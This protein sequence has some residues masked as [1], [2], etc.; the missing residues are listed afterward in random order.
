MLKFLRSNQQVFSVFIFIYC[1]ISV[2]SI[3]FIHPDSV[4]SSA[5]FWTP[6]FGDVTGNLFVFDHRILG[7]TIFTLI[8]L[9]VNGF[10]LA[11]ININHIIIPNR[12]QFPALFLISASSLAFRYE[13]FSTVLVASFFLLFAVDRLFGA[14]QKQGLT[15]RFVDAGILISLGSLFYFN[16]IFFFPFLWLAQFTL[17]PLSLREFLYT[18]VGLAIPFLFIFSGYYL[19]DLSISDTLERIVQ[20]V[21]L[22]RFVDFSW[23]FMAGVLFYLLI[24]LILNFYAINKFA[25]TKIYVR[26]LFQLWFYLFLNSL[27]V[28]FII[29]S[30]GIEI[31]FVMAIPSSVLLSIYFTE[32]RTSFINKVI[33]ILLL[34]TPL[35]INIFW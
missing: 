6:F 7:F 29:P 23:T 4:Y 9:I 19:F 32:C 30:T 2:F 5:P 34:I 26:K 31:L 11:R 20:W 10:Y 33:F 21:R 3:Y 8:I 24:M 13:M 1:L 27:L 14:I 17:R 35:V 12:S 15:Y 16:L 18:L 28:Y 22:N 25:T